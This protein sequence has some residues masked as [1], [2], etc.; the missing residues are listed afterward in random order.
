MAMWSVV[1]TWWGLSQYLLSLAFATLGGGRDVTDEAF[2]HAFG[3]LFLA[4][5]LPPALVAVAM[6][7]AKR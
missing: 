7:R 4:A 3:W 1:A 5:A 2:L 6:L